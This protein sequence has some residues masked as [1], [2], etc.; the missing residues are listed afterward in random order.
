MSADKNG[1]GGQHYFGLHPPIKHII[2]SLYFG[3]GPSVIWV[4]VKRGVL[5]G[6]SK[7]HKRGTNIYSGVILF[8]HQNCMV[9]EP[10]FWGGPRIIPDVC[11][12]IR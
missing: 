7:I 10:Y 11:G 6:G 12:A 1:R 5:I 4:Q 2:T 9:R 8:F 3:R